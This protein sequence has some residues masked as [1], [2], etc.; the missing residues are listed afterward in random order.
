M[1]KPVF[2]KEVKRADNVNEEF[3]TDGVVS[4]IC[5]N[6]TLNKLKLLLE[7]V[8][9]RGTAKLLQRRWQLR[10]RGDV[11]VGAWSGFAC[12]ILGL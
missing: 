12:V 3:E 6:K 1:I 10:V 5:T 11:G 4:K 2:V 7:G 8:V 9:E